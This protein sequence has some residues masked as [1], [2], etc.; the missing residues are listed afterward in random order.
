MEKI[1]LQ[2]GLDRGVAHEI[3]NSLG[4][5]IQA[6]QNIERRTATDFD[7]N[8]VVAKEL[9]VDLDA[10]VLYLNKR[11]IN[12]FISD[13]KTAVDRVSKIVGNKR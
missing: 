6:L 10:V 12:V 13:I 9:N 4:I 3:N 2:E 11:E 7:A 8:R 1:P 5:I